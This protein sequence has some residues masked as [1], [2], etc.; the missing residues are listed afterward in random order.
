[1]MTSSRSAQLQCLQTLSEM[2]EFLDFIGNEGRGRT[3]RNLVSAGLQCFFSSA[4][5][6]FRMLPCLTW[7][8]TFQAI[9]QRLCR[10]NRYWRGGRHV[11]PTLNC[12]LWIFGMML[13]QIGTLDVC[14]CTQTMW[15]TPHA[16]RW[17]RR[18]EICLFQIR[19]SWQDLA[20]VRQVFWAA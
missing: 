15:R 9:F 14:Y 20:E 18:T 10:P 6:S 13:W 16:Y 5:Y 11:N 2:Q 1:M 12:I 19:V 8:K 17:F 7:L 3:F 4:F